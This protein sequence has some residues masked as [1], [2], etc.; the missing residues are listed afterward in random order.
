[1]T[2]L[3][4]LVDLQQDYLAHPR[5]EAAAL[6]VARAADVLQGFRERTWPIVHAWTT[7]RPVP[8]QRMPHWKAAGRWHCVEGTPGHQPP[9]ALR[10]LSTEPV[11]HKTFFSAFE[12]PNLEQILA[13]QAI[14][15][16]VLAG[17]HLHAC[18]RATALDAYA[19]GFAVHIVAD[20][21][22]SYDP[23]HAAITRHYLEDRTVVFQTA[24]ALFQHTPPTAENTALLPAAVINHH[25]RIDTAAGVVRHA[26][27]RQPDTVWHIPHAPTA[28]IDEA[29]QHTRTA[30]ADWKKT[31]P[32]VRQQVLEQLADLIETNADALTTH[33]ADTIG[34]PVRAGQGEVAATAAML[35]AV[36]ARTHQIP[37]PHQ[38]PVRRVPL[39]VVALITPWNNPLYIPLGKMAPALLFGN[40]VVWKPAPAGYPTAVRVMALLELSGVPAG[41]INLVGGG[42]AA[43]RTLMAHPHID[44]VTLTG[45][46][47]AGAAAQVLCA[48]QP[49]PLQ[50]ELGGNNAAIVWHD[51]HLQDAARAVVAGAFG[52]AGQRC[53]ANRRV[54]VDASCYEAFIPLLQH[55]MQALVWGDPLD[56]ATDVGPLIHATQL[57]RV[58]AFVEQARCDGHAVVS[59]HQQPLGDQPD[60]ASYYPPT[61]VLCD[62]AAHDLVQSETFG[63][64]LVVQRAEDWD[65]ALSLCNGV[66]QGL[67]A[68]LFSSSA[69]RQQQ[70]LDRAQAG[71]LKFNQS[72]A[73]AAV[74]RPF[75]GWKATGI[76]PPEHGDSDLD[77]YTRLQAIYA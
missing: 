30:Q 51:A 47:Q 27:P 2:P 58:A 7:V 15:T 28:L 56:P 61:L 13:T 53:T 5:L 36:A 18:I 25:P 39:G 52:M 57:R 1:M 54:I 24:E 20:A 49:R 72:T 73:G 38:Q 66:R 43:S 40:G 62:D 35:R 65:H 34:K 12:D 70:F 4:L 37:A 11:V 32:A 69:S 45:S 19:R 71:I 41:L 60:G 26:S 21:V 9:P 33:L 44:A 23:V 42:I 50:A 63:P 75:G 14:D 67:A 3:L 17:V 55:E 76:G 8:D 48:Q 68:A 6:L 64:V 22:G 29:V 59:H 16:V 77:F 31:T 74:D 46:E 10:P